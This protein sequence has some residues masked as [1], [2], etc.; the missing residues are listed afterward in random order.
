MWVFWLVEY[1][2]LVLIEMLLGFVLRCFFGWGVLCRGR[3]VEFWGVNFLDFAGLC[4][5]MAEW[6]SFWLL[7]F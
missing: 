5:A 2:I 3:M 6:W 7:I 4:S 1:E